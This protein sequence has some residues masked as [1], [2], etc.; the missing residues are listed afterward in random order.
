MNKDYMIYVPQILHIIHNTYITKYNPFKF[1]FKNY[2]IKSC[3]EFN[4]N[5]TLTVTAFM[6]IHIHAP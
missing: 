5:I 3:H 2:V 1:E 6:Y 4:Y